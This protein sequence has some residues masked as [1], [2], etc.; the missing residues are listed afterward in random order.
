[1]GNSYGW[2]VGNQQQ[3][4]KYSSSSPFV[5]RKTQPTPEEV[6][7][8]VRRVGPFRALRLLGKENKSGPHL[9]I[10][11]PEE[12]ADCIFSGEIN[13]KELHLPP[14]FEQRV[15]EFDKYPFY[16][17]LVYSLKSENKYELNRMKYALVQ[18]ELRFVLDTKQGA[19]AY[20]KSEV[21]KVLTRALGAEVQIPDHVDPRTYLL[22]SVSTY[23]WVRQ[24]QIPWSSF[25]AKGL[26]GVRTYNYLD[27]EILAWH[28]NLYYY[29]KPVLPTFSERKKKAKEAAKR[30]KE[31]RVEDF[32][33]EGKKLGAVCND[34]GC[35]VYPSPLSCT[36]E[37]EVVEENSGDSMQAEQ[38][39]CLPGQDPEMETSHLASWGQ[40]YYDWLT[41]SITLQLFH[42]PDLEELPIWDK[43]Y[44]REETAN[45]A[46]PLTPE[47]V[48]I[49]DVFQFRKRYPYGMWKIDFPPEFRKKME[50]IVSRREKNILAV[51]S[52]TD[53]H[54]SWRF[55]SCLR[56]NIGDQNIIDKIRAI[57]FLI[58]SAPPLPGPLVLFRGVQ[59]S[60]LKNFRE[61]EDPRRRKKEEEDDN[62]EEEEEND[63][64]KEEENEKKIL[65][66]INHLTVGDTYQEYGFSSKSY[67]SQ[68]ALKFSR[69][70]CCLL[71]I[72]YPKGHKVLQLPSFSSYFPYE[73]EYITRP[74]ENF[75]V[76]E[77]KY[78]LNPGS[79]QTKI[80]VLEYIQP[81]VEISALEVAER[82]EKD[83]KRDLKNLEKKIAFEEAFER[84]RNPEATK[85]DLK[86]FYEKYL[87]K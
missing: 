74:G 83:V 66:Y 49:R 17:S 2:S 82:I 73:Y 55:N 77:I 67:W 48:K 52:F 9:Y 20:S 25:G 64:S 41:A 18:P 23:P 14:D 43:I 50:E 47:S 30:G 75:R 56:S 86:D 32:E 3:E 24:E 6:K 34:D 37:P 54:K 87:K 4:W 84:A 8:F 13:F 42:S 59:N 12:V 68:A 38:W 21:E 10:R 79:L 35:A 57:S 69:G 36:R 40:K 16:Y 27:G 61:R 65:K 85:K 15:K 81:E 63:A 62:S 53:L 1:M 72:H 7:N 45:L 44:N 11:D 80:I 39:R 78:D 76:K 26:P 22:N 31:A 46:P 51:R 29:I 71:E 28:E 70:G 5:D 33:W 19:R 60:S 58:E